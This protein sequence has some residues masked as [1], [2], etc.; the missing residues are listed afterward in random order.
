MQ[1][2]LAELVPERNRKTNFNCKIR[3]LRELFCF[4]EAVVDDGGYG[5]VGIVGIVTLST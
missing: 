2:I 4:V 5:L 1:V 3:S